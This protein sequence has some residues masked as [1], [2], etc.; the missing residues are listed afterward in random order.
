ML[1]EHK[2]IGCQRRVSTLKDISVLNL[3][4]YCILVEVEYNIFLRNTGNLI[5]F[6]EILNVVLNCIHE[7]TIQG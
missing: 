1:M 7:R 2:T 6:V 3:S 4:V 5:V